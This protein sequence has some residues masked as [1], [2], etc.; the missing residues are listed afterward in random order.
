MHLQS[1]TSPL[2][3]HHTGHWSP[4]RPRPPFPPPPG[5]QTQSISFGLKHK[6]LLSGLQQKRSRTVCKHGDDSVGKE[7]FQSTCQLMPRAHKRSLRPR[8]IGGALCSLTIATGRRTGG[9]RAEDPVP[10]PRSHDKNSALLT[11]HI[12]ATERKWTER[13]LSLIHI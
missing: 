4:H 11:N 7:R 5:E 12:T 8:I 9:A 10:Q 13:S 3:K 1:R 6:P 2:L